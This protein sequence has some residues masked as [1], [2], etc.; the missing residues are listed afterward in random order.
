MKYNL[1]D[2]IYIILSKHKITRPFFKIIINKKKK[3]TYSALTD[4]HRKTNTSVVFFVSKGN[5]N[6]I[7]KYV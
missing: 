4:M 1:Y 3:N 6:S 2:E 7:Y 5:P